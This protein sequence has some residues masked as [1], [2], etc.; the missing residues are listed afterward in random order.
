MDFGGVE[1]FF[2]LG[3]DD[4]LIENVKKSPL[5]H[6]RSNRRYRRGLKDVVYAHSGESQS[7]PGH[8]IRLGFTSFVREQ[9]AR[10]ASRICRPIGLAHK[11]QRAGSLT[12]VRVS[13]PIGL[14]VACRA[15]SK[16][17]L[18]GD[19]CAPSV[20]F[21]QGPTDSFTGAAGVCPSAAAASSRRWHADIPLRN[22]TAHGPRPG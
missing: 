10:L 4:L 19:Y 2:E 6:L 1:Y 12:I 21:A 16:H 18:T 14:P 3:H 15:R 5:T 9:P 20:D 13:V 8:R 17:S 7:S 11:P 22:R